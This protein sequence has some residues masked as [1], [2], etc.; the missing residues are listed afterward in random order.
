MKM[1]SE[2][3][4]GMPGMENTMDAEEDAPHHGT[5]SGT[6]PDADHPN[7][8]NEMKK[9]PASAEPSNLPAND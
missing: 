2:Q 6:A 1:E 8:K 9:L 4:K 5:G 3:D 7:M